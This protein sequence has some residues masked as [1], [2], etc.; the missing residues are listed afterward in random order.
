MSFLP[1]FDSTP[2]DLGS[3]DNS[4]SQL[5]PDPILYTK[6]YLISFNQFE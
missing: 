5:G 1:L 2:H 3:V 4:P 6:N